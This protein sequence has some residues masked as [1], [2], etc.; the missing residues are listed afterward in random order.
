MNIVSRHQEIPFT[1]V[2]VLFPILNMGECQSLWCFSWVCANLT[3]IKCYYDVYAISDI[4]KDALKVLL[5]GTYFS[6]H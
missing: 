2:A 1:K 3:L 4:L 6:Y 5:N